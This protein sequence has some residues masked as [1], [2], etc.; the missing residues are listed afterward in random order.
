MYASPLLLEQ[1]VKEI[2][3]VWR[4]LVQN[5]KDEMSADNFVFL[6]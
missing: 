6:K 1:I 4:N 3:D 5:K 2:F